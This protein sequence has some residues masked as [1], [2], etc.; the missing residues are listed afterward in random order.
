MP[1]HR[2]SW[3]S[4]DHRRYVVGFYRALVVATSRT[5]RRSDVSAVAE[6]SPI[7]ERA[8]ERETGLLNR[9][10]SWNSFESFGSR[11]MTTK[12]ERDIGAATA[13]FHA[14]TGQGGRHDRCAR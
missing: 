11:I 6:V 10:W 7:G 3:N 14:T 13:D 4:C 1:M 12:Y 8:R 9:R 2:T 5:S